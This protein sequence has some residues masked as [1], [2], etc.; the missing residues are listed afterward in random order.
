MLTIKESHSDITFRADCMAASRSDVVAAC[1]TFL[2]ARGAPEGAAT[3]VIF[4]ELLSNAIWHGNKN[5]DEPWVSAR[6]EHLGDDSFSVTVQD[7]GEGFDYERD[8]RGDIPEDLR[9][10]NRRGYFL[11]RVL[12]ERIEFS[13][14]GNCIT[15]YISENRKI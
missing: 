6:I 13:E 10:G 14:K 7:N 5:T 1:K 12:S 3:M 11:I 15:A 9:R 4:R 8:A 2:L